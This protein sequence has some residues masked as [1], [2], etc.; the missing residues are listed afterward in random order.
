MTQD[1]I[2]KMARQAGFS[3]AEG[4]VTGGI[5]DVKR[6]AKLVAEKEREACAEIAEMSIEVMRQTRNAFVWNLNTDLD[7]IPACKKWAKMLRKN[8]D[9]LDKAIA[10]AEKQRDKHD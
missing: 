5:T 4:I 1:E 10:E 3:I 6:F 9:D 2:I 7:N 8:I